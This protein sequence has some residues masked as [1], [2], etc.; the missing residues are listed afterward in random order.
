MRAALLL[1]L[2][3]VLCAAAPASA[4]TV[5]VQGAT[6][7]ITAGAG[8]RNSVSVSISGSR[9]R[10]TDSVVV[11]VAGA[12]CTLSSRTVSCP[13]AGLT[14]VVAD[15]ADQNDR[16]T[17]GRS[18]P[19]RGIVRGGSGNDT[20]ASGSGPDELDGG[21]GYDTVSYS[22]RPEGVVVTLD[23]IANDGRADEGDNLV[24][25]NRVIG[26]QSIDLLTGSTGSERL[27][28]RG[29]DDRLFGG[30]GNDTLVGNT[31][32][33]ALDGGEG[34]D[35]FLA[36]PTPDGADALQGGPGSDR[37][38]YSARRGGV[39]V[40]ADGRPDDG[41][42][43]GGLSFVGPVPVVGLLGSSEGDLVQPDVETLRGGQ[44][45]DVLG[46][47]PT[48]GRLL[49]GPGTD[50][51]AGGAGQDTF[52]GGTGFDRI[53]SRDDRGEGILC[54]DQ[55]DRAYVDVLDRPAGDCEH[56]AT[57]FAV[58][59]AAL[60]RTAGADGGV[61]V[62]VACP[63]QAAVHC[64]GTL[65]AETLR[66]IKGRKVR[67]G[68]AGYSTA[69][70]TTVDVTIPVSEAGRAALD[71]FGGATRVRVVA[72]TRDEAGPGRDALLRF[73]LRAG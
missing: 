40:D 2:P 69:A 44:G 12:G 73:V 70:G 26:T 1:C 7:S 64:T 21:T 33:D 11:P 9:I 4:A 3:L 58:G 72:R 60:D 50:V 19:L 17:L 43:P 39:V 24:S 25:A 61:V 22:G 8:E 52:E 6:L 62:R 42:L 55:T 47:A 54:G 29:N 71:R 27:D 14:D 38:D 65:R 53:L 48:G 57:R 23:G 59:L 45:D 20:L 49:G 41:D 67:V 18:I 32:R 13:R 36:D 5:G 31:G 30:G 35:T 28:G 37:A 10:V 46:A 68:S 34:N 16:V 51:L 56:V 15:V 66:R 63:G